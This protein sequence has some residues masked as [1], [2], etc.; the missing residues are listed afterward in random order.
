VQETRAQDVDR[1]KDCQ[2]ELA[3]PWYLHLRSLFADLERASVH[4]HGRLLDVGCGN[5]PYERMF[6][7][8]VSEHIGCDVVQSSQHRVDVICPATSLSFGDSSFDTV[9]CTQVI[10]HVVDHK[11]LLSESFRVLKSGGVLILSGP[12]YWPLHE[13]PHDFFRFTKHGLK[14]LLE[15]AGFVNL[16]IVNNGGKWALTGQV[17]VHAIEGTRVGYSF[18]IRALNR[19]FAYV[20]DWHPVQS[21]TINYLVVAHKP[22][23]PCDSTTLPVPS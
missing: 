13:E 18:I 7:C 19:L 1:L 14:Y 22:A 11:Q 15:E 21:N 4:A 16:E 12:M 9:L 8:R 5:K 23:S 2:L 3:N 6:T 17:L 10:E 20:D